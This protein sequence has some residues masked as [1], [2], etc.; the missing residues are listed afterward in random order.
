MKLKYNT[1]F[2][3]I[4]ELGTIVVLTRIYVKYLGST[5]V[6]NTRKSVISLHLLSVSIKISGLNISLVVNLSIKI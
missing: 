2:H 5:F 6:H 3:V 1:V 4:H